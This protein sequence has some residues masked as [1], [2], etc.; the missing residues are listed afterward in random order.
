MPRQAALV[1]CEW[2]FDEMTPLGKM[3]YVVLGGQAVHMGLAFFGCSSEEIA[4]HSDPDISEPHRLKD[5]DANVTFDY[6]TDERVLFQS[7]RND[8]YWTKGVQV[9]IYPILNVDPAALHRICVRVAKLCPKNKFG[10]RIN[11]LCG[12]C[13]CCACARPSATRPTRCACRWRWATS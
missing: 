8:K 3:T 2:T 1:V 10:Y 5:D 7:V 9:R 12:G 6:H 11:P 4:A 13:W